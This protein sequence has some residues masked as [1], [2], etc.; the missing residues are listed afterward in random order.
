M[1]ILLMKYGVNVTSCF[2]LFDTE[3]RKKHSSFHLHNTKTKLCHSQL[4]C[5]LY[6]V[7]ERLERILA[8]V[9]VDAGRGAVQS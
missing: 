5:L 3:N 7:A 2:V 8:A 4:D 1:N 9:S 6:R